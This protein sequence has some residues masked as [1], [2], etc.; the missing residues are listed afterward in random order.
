M[1]R[2]V[3][4]ALLSCFG[5][6]SC[7]SAAQVANAASPRL[8][9][10]QERYCAKLREGP[11]AYVFFVRRLKPIYAY[12]YTDFV[13]EYRGAAVV[14]DCRVGP[15]RVAAVHAFLRAEVVAVR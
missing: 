7:E 12:T 10:T 8:T 15:E 13:P 4:I 11:E 3:A 9:P 14:A 1:Q 6:G 5:A 2:F